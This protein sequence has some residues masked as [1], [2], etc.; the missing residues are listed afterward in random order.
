MA[1]ILSVLFF[2]GAASASHPPPAGPYH[3]PSYGHH[4]CDPKAPPAC[5]NASG[6]AYCLDDPYYP[7]YELK[8]AISADY[9]FAKKYSDIVDQSAND[10]VE[11]IA[12][13]QEEGFNYEYYSGAS[14]GPSP[15]D[16]SHWIGPEGYL[17]PSD[18]KYAMPRRASNVNGEWRVIVNHVHYY[19]QTT[20][21]ETCLFPDSACR[22]LAPCYKSKC[23]QKYVYQRM[24]SYDPCDPYKGLFIDIYKFPSA[25]SCHIPQ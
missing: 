5:A 13:E 16:A 17:C 8:S 6:L 18:V 20:R 12:K 19:T 1:L 3:A 24:V 11:L 7:E 2:V 9:L 25:C 15:Y 22:L 23:T 4:Y 10:L 14:K 21:F